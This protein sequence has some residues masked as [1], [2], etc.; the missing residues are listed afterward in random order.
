MEVGNR[1]WDLVLLQK[2]LHRTHNK[3]YGMAEALHNILYFCVDR[4]TL[5]SYISRRKNVDVN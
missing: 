1:K 4:S 5:T 3:L 2:N